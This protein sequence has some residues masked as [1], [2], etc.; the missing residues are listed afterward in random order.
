MK[1]MHI[2]FSIA[3]LAMLVPV[4]T[5]SA[6]AEQPA[7]AKPAKVA[8]KLPPRRPSAGFL[9]RKSEGGVI[10]LLNRSGKETKTIRET[11]ENMQKFCR[12]AI[13]S[14]DEKP[15][16]GKDGFAVASEAIQDKGKVAIAVVISNEGK[17]K[18]MLAAYPDDRMA[19]INMDRLTDL[20]ASDDVV[21]KRLQ[22]ELWRAVA[23]A[24]GGYASDFPCAMRP[25]AD[26]KGLDANPVR[27][28]CPP[29]CGK[30]M[31]A[32]KVY[33]IATVQMVPYGVAVAQGWAPA[34]T[35]DLQKAVW[36]R[37]KANQAKAKD[38]AK[39]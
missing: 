35:N 22:S 18:P 23:F 30:I 26:V 7:A 38:E 2:L 3:A 28:A 34:P 8:R 5:L 13:E 16:A 29:V 1:S 17:D 37:V 31:Q 25:V 36:D 11:A 20:M 4:I 10:L 14:R 32:A 6:P 27:M 39:K 33:G 12:V 21:A 15:V 19:V 24:A 9:T